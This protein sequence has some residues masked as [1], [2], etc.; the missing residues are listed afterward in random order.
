MDLG[1]AKV[2][3]KKSKNNLIDLRTAHL[4]DELPETGLYRNTNNITVEEAANA[5][6]QKR[7]PRWFN[8]IF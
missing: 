8:S 1:D 2:A 4:I 5:F 6:V 7:K 3:F